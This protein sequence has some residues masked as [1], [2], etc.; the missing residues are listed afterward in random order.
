MLLKPQQSE[1]SCL[2][3]DSFFY[4]FFKSLGEF[5][6]SIYAEYLHRAQVGDLQGNTE[7]KNLWG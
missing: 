5:K 7:R 6:I 2:K 4:N 3:W 1:S